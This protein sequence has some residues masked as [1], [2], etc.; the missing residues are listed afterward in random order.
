[1]DRRRFVILVADSVGC[2][3]LPDARAYGDEGSDT[4]G[5]TSRAVGGLALPVMGRMGLGH[6]TPI[7]GVPPEPSPAAFHG[8]MSERSKGKD[9]ITGHWEMMGIVLSEPLA[10]CPHGFPPEILEP[11]LRETGAPGVLGNVVASGTEIIQRLG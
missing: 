4:L 3:A 2:G 5:N 11:F 9:T 1:M 8:R 6:L 7:L 10:L